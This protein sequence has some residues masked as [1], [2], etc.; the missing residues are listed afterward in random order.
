VAEILAYVIHFL[1]TANNS[2]IALTAQL[3]KKIQNMLQK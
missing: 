3:I 1:K 2:I